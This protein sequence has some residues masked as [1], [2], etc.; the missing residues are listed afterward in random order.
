MPNVVIL[1]YFFTVGQAKTTLALNNSP[2][3]RVISF[4]L[5]KIPVCPEKGMLYCF[6]MRLYQKPACRQAGSE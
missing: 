1:L 5:S 3:T 4:F 2:E 6:F